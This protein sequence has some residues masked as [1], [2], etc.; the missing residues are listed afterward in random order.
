MLELREPAAPDIVI[1]IFYRHVGQ[2]RPDADHYRVVDV[3]LKV[4]GWG[5]TEPQP[6]EYP[7]HIEHEALRALR[8]ERPN[9]SVKSVEHLDED[10]N[11]I[12]R[13][14]RSTTGR[15]RVTVIEPY[16]F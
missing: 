9:G 1:E 14:A 12:P 15:V 2:P 8:P 13:P 7:F 5:D 16:I 3:T 4:R 6:C 11:V 10:G